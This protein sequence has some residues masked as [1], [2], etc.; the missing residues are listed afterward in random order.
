MLLKVVH[1]NDDD[2]VS[3]LVFRPKDFLDG[4]GPLSLSNHLYFNEKH[5]YKESVNCQRLMAKYPEDLHQQGR[6]K[7]EKDSERK[8][9]EGKEAVRYEGFVSAQVQTVRTLNESNHCFDVYHSPI[10]GN[11]AHCDIQ[12][13]F[14]G[15]KPQTSQRN[16]L[17]EKLARVFSEIIAA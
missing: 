11:M 17:R 7:A 2:T 8:K 16:L 9:K 15:T 10:K 1:I 14:T 5:G 6:L 4:V 3:R 12:L 13:L